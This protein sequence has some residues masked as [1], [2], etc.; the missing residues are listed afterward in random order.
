MKSTKLELTRVKKA[1]AIR[2]NNKSN[3]IDEEGEGL[4]EESREYGK[5]A[6]GECD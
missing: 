1:A 2:R 6:F 5:G 3:N 4:V